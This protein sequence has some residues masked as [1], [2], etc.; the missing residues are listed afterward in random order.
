MPVSEGALSCLAY[1]EHFGLRFSVTGEVD[2]S[3]HHA[4][5][6]RDVVV[7]HDYRFS[8]REDLLGWRHRPGSV[9][10]NILDEA[11]DFVGRLENLSADTDVIR[12]RLEIPH[13]FAR[14]A[15]E[16]RREPPRLSTRTADTIR[17]LYE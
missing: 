10:G 2:F 12:E 6:G 7:E 11:V 17:R 9:H 15:E 5:F 1:P 16:R 3:S 13:G 8:R 14:H 4:L